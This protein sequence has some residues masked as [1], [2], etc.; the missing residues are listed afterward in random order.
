MR[1]SNS[2]KKKE[3]HKVYVGISGG[4]DSAVSAAILKDQGYEVY[5]VFMKNWSGEDYGLEGDC[6]WREDMKSAEEVCKHLKIDFRSYNFEKEYSEK[7]IR[8]F[9]DEYEKGR[10]PNPDVICNKEIKFSI[11]LEKAIADGAQYIATGHYVRKSE[12][13]SNINYLL[14]GVDQK[15][16]QSY[17]LYNITQNQLLHSLFPIG[18]YQKNEVRSLA[19][20]IGLPNSARPDSQGICFVGEINVREFIKSK[21]GIKKGEIVDI[22][23]EKIVGEH[24][25][26]YFYTIGQREGLGIGGTRVP[27]FVVE[28]NKEKNIVYVSLGKDNPHLYSRDIY[29]ENLHL[30][31]E[32]TQLDKLKLTGSIRYRHKDENLNIIDLDALHFKFETPQR[33]IT[34]GQSL[35]L[36]SNEVCIGGGIIS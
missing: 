5:G 18:K 8:Y 16:D 17:F 9:F 2:V 27:Y 23:S 25:G 30:I 3:N 15:K 11:F 20:K 31:N 35:V 10:T 26:Y 4:V 32:D 24:D 13:K 28:I 33:A 7:V 12:D 21:L 34:P 19:K 22:D 36:Y 29:L 1:L 6:P 14:K